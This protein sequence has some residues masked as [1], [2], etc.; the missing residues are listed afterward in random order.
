MKRQNADQNDD[1]GAERH[2]KVDEF[3]GVVS[4]SLEFFYLVRLRLAGPEAQRSRKKR[5]RRNV[6]KPLGMQLFQERKMLMQDM[7]AVGR[8]SGFGRLA[9]EEVEWKEWK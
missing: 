7:H 4:L 8:S 9:P 2:Y 1:D 5:L 6:A 3:H